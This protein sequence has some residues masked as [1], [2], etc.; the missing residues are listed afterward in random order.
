MNPNSVENHSSEVQLIWSDLSWSDLC[1][2]RDSVVAATF[3]N[4]APQTTVWYQPWCCNMGVWAPRVLSPETIELH[5]QTKQNKASLQADGESKVSSNDGVKCVWTSCA[6]FFFVFSPWGRTF[7]RG[8]VESSK[9]TRFALLVESR[10]RHIRRRMIKCRVT[11]NKNAV[12]SFSRSAW[13]TRFLLTS[14]DTRCDIISLIKSRENHSAEGSSSNLSG[15]SESFCFCK[16]R[17]ASR[18]ASYR[19]KQNLARSLKARYRL[20]LLSFGKC[21]PM[22]CFHSAQ[23]LICYLSK[24]LLSH[25]KWKRQAG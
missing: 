11:S 25:E 22:I 23:P 1:F 19:K 3:H 8:W 17:G 6:C 13:W 12:W 2:C 18:S 15:Y 5:L 21:L 4:K 16:C 10:S 24:L 20:C 14:S 7:T 9:I